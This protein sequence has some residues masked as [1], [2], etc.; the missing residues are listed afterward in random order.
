M[1][2]RHQLILTTLLSLGMAASAQAFDLN[3]AVQAAR[4]YDAGYAGARATLQAGQEKAVQGRAQL[5]K[6]AEA[7]NREAIRNGQ[8]AYDAP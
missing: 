5:R 3:E 8:R 6:D 1:K 4:N 2:Q 7:R